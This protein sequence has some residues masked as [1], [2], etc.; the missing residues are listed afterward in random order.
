MTVEEIDARIVL[1]THAMQ[2]RLR[3]LRDETL[4]DELLKDFAAFDE[5]YRQRLTAD[6]DERVYRREVEAKLKK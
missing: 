6:H 2:K 5:L 3:A 4:R 1:I